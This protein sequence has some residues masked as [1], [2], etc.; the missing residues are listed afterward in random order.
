MFSR[1]RARLQIRK[2]LA[3]RLRWSRNGTASPWIT[4]ARLG[5]WPSRRLRSRADHLK[6]V[7][8]V[9]RVE[10]CICPGCLRFSRMGVSD[11]EQRRFRSDTVRHDGP[12]ELPRKATAGLP[13]RP[14]SPEGSL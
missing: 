1:W 5:N 13:R 4:T 3:A 8:E 11:R 7:H 10:A 14:E 2:W 12:E 9:I 6:R